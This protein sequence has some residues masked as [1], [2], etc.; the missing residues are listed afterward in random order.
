MK[1]CV[2]YGQGG[3]ITSFGMYLLSQ[4]IAS[5]YPAAVVTNYSWDDPAAIA[6]DIAQWKASGTGHLVVIGY[7]LGANCVTWLPAYT[8]ARIDLAVCYDPSV[9]SI[10][11]NPAATIK[12]LLLYHNSD[13]EPE[14][15][16][17]LVGP[18]V[19]RTEISMLHLSVCYSE[20]LHQ[21]T[22]AAIAQ[23]FR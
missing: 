7:S 6:A 14:G 16:A 11:T 22:L 19:E 9:L 18:Q 4:R 8:K 21:K 17:V 12:R 10:V 15:H 23:L 20:V 13:W 1:V 3:I 2:I 5:L